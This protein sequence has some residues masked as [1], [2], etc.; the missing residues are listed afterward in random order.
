[1]S[2]SIEIV[3]QSAMDRFYGDYKS[4]VMYWELSDFILGCGMA[5]AAACQRMYL[6][7]YAESRADKDDSVVAFDPLILNDQQLKVDKTTKFAKFEVPVMAFGFSNQSVGIQ[8]VTIVEPSNSFGDEIER[9]P[10]QSQ[11]QL[12]LLPFVNK[13][14]YVPKND[15]IQIVKKGNCNVSLVNVA[16]VPAGTGGGYSIPDGM[17]DEVIMECISIIRE[18]RLP[19]VKKTNDQNP[20]MVMETEMNKN[21]LK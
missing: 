1:M 16:Y 10:S 20:N 7:Q 9:Q 2:V 19:V 14:F 15:G 6:V 3:A 12:G 8:S 17:A 18:G 21:A 13:I 11:W 5:W 4:S